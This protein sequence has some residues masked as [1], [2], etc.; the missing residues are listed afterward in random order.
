VDGCRIGIHR[1]VQG[2]TGEHFYTASIPE[3]QCC[4]FIL[5]AANFYYLYAGPHAGLAAFYRCYT[6]GGF[7]FYT[8]DPGC[9]G[10]PVNEGI[11]GYIAT[12]EGTAGSVPLYRLYL[13]GNGDHFYTTSATERDTAV[14]SGYVNEGVAGFVW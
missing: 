11:L 1:S 2:A 3:A 9:E 13:A 4:G 5:E 6:P 8:Q 7:H 12:A 10:V 14:A